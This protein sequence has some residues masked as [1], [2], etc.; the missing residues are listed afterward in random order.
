MTDDERRVLNRE[1]AE[2]A[3]YTVQ[4][5]DGGTWGQA[6][7]LFLPNG[8]RWLNPSALWNTTPA[9]NLESQA[10]ACAPDFVRDLG[11]TTAMFAGRRWTFSAEID[12]SDPDCLEYVVWV[13]TDTPPEYSG[14][15]P[16]DWQEAAAIALRNALKAKA[17][18]S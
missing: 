9:F 15:S 1:I 16:L 11:F 6:Y 18:Q 17:S 3:G 4:K 13:E 10:W 8:G 12:D 14:R 7:A 2:L 5:V